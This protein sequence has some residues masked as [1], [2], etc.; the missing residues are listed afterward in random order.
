MTKVNIK[1]DIP[2]NLSLED[3]SSDDFI[4]R[5]DKREITAEVCE[6]ADDAIF[7][8]V[9]KGLTAPNCSELPQKSFTEL[10]V[11]PTR[12]VFSVR[13]SKRIY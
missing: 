2:E 13:C 6:L 7:C 5:T 12:F 8:K 11:L 3:H 10:K 1:T 9:V 4:G